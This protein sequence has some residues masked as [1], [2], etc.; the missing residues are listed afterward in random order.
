MGFSVRFPYICTV[1]TDQ[2]RLPFLHPP[3]PFP[4]SIIYYS[5]FKSNTLPFIEKHDIY[6]VSSLFHVLH[7]FLCS[8]DGHSAGCLCECEQSHNIHGYVY[9]SLAYW[10]HFPWLYTQSGIARS[11]DIV[12]VCVNK[13][14]KPKRNASISSRVTL[15]SNNT[16][17]HTT[18]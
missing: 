16:E 14:R 1:C 10:F 11:H 9:I 6:Y 13:N 3:T 7:F 18:I 4:I 12:L 15:Y 2:I 8:F 17:L 5:T